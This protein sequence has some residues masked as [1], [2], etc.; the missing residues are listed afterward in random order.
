MAKPRLL[1]ALWGALSLCLAAPAHAGGE[2]VPTRTALLVPAGALDDA[3]KALAVQSH[4][5]ILYAPELVAGRRVTG[6]HA[7]LEP[8]QA[9]TRLLRGSGLR[10]VAVN[11]N[12]FLLQRIE[13]ARGPTPHNAGRALPTEMASIQVTGSRIPRSD[14]NLVTPA[15]LTIITR[16]EIE[17]SGHQTLF[18]L[19]RMQPGMLGHHPVDVASEGG[20]GDQQPFAAAATT[21]LNGLGPRATLFLIDG[22]R[23]AN[24][25]L[26]S[27]DLGGLTDLDAIPLS[28]VER[29]EIIRGGASAIYGA[30]AMAGVVNIILM[31]Q[32]DGGEVVARYGVSERGDAG[33]R[34]L[35]FS[36]GVNTASGSSLFLGVDHLQRDALLGSQRDWRT[37]DYRRR[38]S[39]GDWRIPLGYR[40]S[41]DNLV[42]PFCPSGV[43]QLDAG[44]H[45]DRVRWSTLQPRSERRSLYTHWQRDLAQGLQLSA[46]IRISDATQQLQN[47]PFHA[48]VTVPDSHPDAIPGTKLAY[49]LFDIGP[50]HNHNSTRSLDVATSLQGM[51][52]EWDW[53]VGLSHDENKVRNQGNGLLRETVFIDAVFANQYRFGVWDNPPALLAAISPPVVAK[54]K[55]TLDQL[56]AG[57]NGRWFNL[58][59]GEARLAAGVEFN[60]DSLQH[61]PDPLMQENDVALGPQKIPVDAHRYGSAL[62]AELNLPL[63]HRLQADVA[64]RLDHRQGYG[65]KTSPK[66]G[67]KWQVHEALTF[68]GTAATGY[69]APSL[70]ELR[71]P[72]VLEY[73]DVVRETPGLGP[74][75]V[76]AAGYCL[77]LRGAQENPHLEPETSRSHTLGLVWA[78]T[79]AFSLSVDQFR[80]ERR[81]EIL[82]GSAIDDPQSFPLS[83]QRDEN[84]L[85]VGIN[86]YF[87]NVGR[88]DVRG[89]EWEGRYRLETERVGRWSFHAAGQFLTRVARQPHPG[90]AEL[91][92]AG[93]RSPDTSGSA[94]VQWGVANWSST[95][96]LHYRGDVRVARPDEGCPFYN[97]QAK[98]CRT[99]SSKTLDL[100]VAYLGFDDWQLALNVHNLR[101][102]NP[103]NYDVEKGGY[104]I[105]YDDPRGRY[106]L[107][108]ATW[109]F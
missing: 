16:E 108:S 39:L 31:K 24:Y 104:D 67:F 40:D 102:R 61:R 88:T 48:L 106:Y 74:C 101:D 23:I 51:L 86:D 27:V 5:Q 65:S 70:F 13:P 21:S 64:A 44:C 73:S 94:S 37:F 83:L 26:I 45:F 75:R 30:D 107:L 29:V 55:A 103:V 98:K 96:S 85:L 33:E 12:T 10:V 50:I 14:L 56:A 69:R 62:Y 77:V 92:Y 49:A 22:R 6:L 76:A 66:L 43:A 95:L 57:L 36:Q 19:L 53:N 63:T 18:E 41:D 68:R 97:A 109:R 78:P 4:I 71:R 47:P 52:G 46:G 82:P 28:I 9:L 72:T 105:A 17:T 7:R 2:D 81:N 34:R 80:I 35:S 25:G 20:Q 15:P 58:P 99:P 87:A 60:R 3:L 100:N 8:T 54:G 32:R 91:N 90:V 11:A 93:Y 89:W 79:P 42:K 84:G 59:A 1:F 38:Y